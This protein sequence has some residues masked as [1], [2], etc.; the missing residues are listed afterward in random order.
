MFEVVG[1]GSSAAFKHAAD[2]NPAR[3]ASPAQRDRSEPRET[4]SRPPISPC[5]A[6]P[7]STSFPARRPH[8]RHRKAPG[9]SDHP[10]PHRPAGPRSLQRRKSWWQSAPVTSR[11]WSSSPSTGRDDA[12]EGGAVLP[13]QPRAAGGLRQGAAFRRPHTLPR[14]RDSTSPW[15]TPKPPFKTEVKQLG[16]RYCCTNRDL[17]L[18]VPVGR[19]ETDF[20]MEAGA[21]LAA[22]R[23]LTGQPTPPRP[24]Y[25]EG[26]TAVAD[27]LAPV[28]EL[29]FAFGSPPR[30]TPGPGRSRQVRPRLRDLLRLY[31]GPPM[32]DSAATPQLLLHHPQA[33]RRRQEHA[34]RRYP[35]RQQARPDLLRPRPGSAAHH[36]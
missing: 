28:A 17:P 15:W 35:P 25:A 32:R 10:R 4:S 23:S 29:P 8:P 16:V 26:D 21:P 14:R 9:V 12:G 33:D 31:A 24:S 36:G 20:T 6:R 22:I 18:T 5:S 1:D 3:S 34:A 13:G 30:T 19:G 2:R 11:S 27:H 7:P